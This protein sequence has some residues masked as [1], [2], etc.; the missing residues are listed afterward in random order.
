MGS[1]SRSTPSSETLPEGV[2]AQKRPKIP[3]KGTLL[4][5]KYRVEDFLGA[6]A[7][8]GVV[9]A[10]HE[11]LDEKVAL[12]ILLP[13]HARDAE[14][15]ARFKREA[16]AAFKLKSEH[17]CRVLD[18]GDLDDGV[19]FIVMEF[20]QGKTLAALLRERA[21]FPIE[22]AVD[23]LLQACAGLADA[24]VND[25]VHR[26]L[27]PSNFV[28]T[29]RRDGSTCLKVIDFGV[30]KVVT[31][32]E[33]TDTFGYIGSPTYSSPEQFVSARSATAKSDQWALGVLLYIMVMGKH[34]FDFPTNNFAVVAMTISK[35]PPLPMC[36]SNPVVPAAIEAI[37]MRC[38]SKD[39]ADRFESVLALADA[40]A[41][42]G[43]GSLDALSRSR[44][45]TIA[46]RDPGS[47]PPPAVL[48]PDT[49]QEPATIEVNYPVQTP[50]P[51][52]VMARA[53]TPFDGMRVATPIDPPRRSSVSAAL[54]GALVVALLVLGGFGFYVWKREQERSATLLPLVATATAAPTPTVP[55]ALS[56]A[57][58]PVA[59]IATVASAV[60][61]TADPAASSPPTKGAGTHVPRHVPPPPPTG[62]GPKIMKDWQGGY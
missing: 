41:P 47:F 49:L 25:I 14:L 59:P 60:P 3:E 45:Q 13:A 42:Y 46:R 52:P 56:S 53:D 23:Y 57:P 15:R 8:G 19:P 20:L 28:L 32:R 6:G 5:G 17:V 7:M 1:E 11:H 27:K 38:L 21:P 34:P 35:K 62:S 50:L 26:D 2:P 48:S 33:V 9:S 24:H 16:Q 39:P 58:T 31:D 12:K 51:L 40:L 61:S 29:T 54:A 55:P 22:E 43:S 44:K 10:R 18:A 37:V 36:E 4:L 30:S